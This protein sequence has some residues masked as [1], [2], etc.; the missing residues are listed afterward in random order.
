MTVGT[1]A[2]LA[3]ITIRS[4]HHYDDIGLV[5]PRHRTEAGYRVYGRQEVERL[6]EVLFF[7]ELGFSLAEIRALVD[8]PDYHRR[9]ALRDQRSMLIERID[10]LRSMVSAIDR[11][12]ELQN[13]DTMSEEE[14]L[15]VF[16]EFTPGD[17][18]A[19]VEERWGDTDAYRQSFARTGSY[20]KDDWL[21]IKA[22]AADIEQA[23]VGLLHDGVSADDE[24]AMDVAERHR[25]HIGDWFYDCGYDMHAGLAE[26][27]V[28]DPRFT[29]NLDAIAPGLAR[30]MRDAIVANVARR[31]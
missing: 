19:E 16:G 29:D 3:G 31:S 18:A 23:F 14:M 10:R 22:E 6:Q 12:L 2:G 1:V 8:R 15:E 17:Y 28:T 9:E 20:T 24:A 26:L 21:R 13:G 7:R 5:T 27:Y 11:T 30:Y 4:L 25:K